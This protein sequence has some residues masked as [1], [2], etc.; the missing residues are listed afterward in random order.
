MTVGQ[1]AGP[2]AVPGGISIL[3]KIDQRQVLTADPRDAVMSLK[4]VAISFPKGT[5]QPQATPR[6]E[7]FAAATRLI[8]GCGTVQAAA[9]EF[10]AEVVD[11]DQVRI[12]DLPPQLQ[13]VLL[14]LQIGQATPPFG[15]L[16]EGVRVLVLCG[17]DDPQ[18]AGGPSFDAIMAQLEEERINRRAR[19]YLRD[20]RRD[21]VVDYQ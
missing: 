12:R 18:V 10:G 21:A 20:L 14:K 4:Q 13:D 2:I 5:T 9:T 1:V 6:V 11:N 19:R 8:S 17:R 16:E 3:V 7:K 15:S